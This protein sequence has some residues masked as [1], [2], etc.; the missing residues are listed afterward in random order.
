MY[1]INYQSARPIRGQ[2]YFSCGNMR[3]F[4]LESFDKYPVQAWIRKDLQA[5][6]VLSEILR[7]RPGASVRIST[8]SV[9]E[10]SLRRLFG[11]RR[12]YNVAEMRVIIDRKA[13]IKTH[14]LAQLI[15]NIFDSAVLS[16]IHAKV[17]IVSW[18]DGLCKS[19]VVVTSQNLTR[20]NRFESSVLIA[21]LPQVSQLTESFDR[22]ES[23]H[24]IPVKDMFPV[25]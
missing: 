22:I 17:M 10:E 5:T 9:A 23:H 16:D 11:I 15:Y 21:G 3:I 25:I 12:K 6:D 8:F 18:P 24:S 4:K 1:I 19:V 7:D 2:H 14:S 13:T 20:G